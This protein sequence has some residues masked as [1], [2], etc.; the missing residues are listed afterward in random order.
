MFKL[1][2]TNKLVNKLLKAWIFPL[3]LHCT[4]DF[5]AS[6]VT[7]LE[8]SEII[9]GS[10]TQR[11]TPCRWGTGCGAILH[12]LTPTAISNHLKEHHFEFWDDRARGQCQWEGT[13][14]RNGMD[15]YF[16][17]FGKHVAC[18]HL[19][20]TTEK[21]RYC[22]ETFSR[23]DVLVRH[24]KRYCPG[25]RQI[26]DTRYILE[27]IST[28]DNE[29]FMATARFLPKENSWY[30]LLRRQCI[31]SDLGL[32][33]AICHES[34]KMFVMNHYNAPIKGNAVDLTTDFMARYA[35]YPGWVYV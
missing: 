26:F 18:V 16:G 24:E 19:R 3:Y 6:T 9:F 1:T 14:C 2:E 4:S 10:N 25:Q 31:M 15:M 28:G 34:I 29:R 30:W 23:P 7:T 11:A 27:Y 12:N 20:S 22:G 5:N 8:R 35:T 13:S 21:C 33:A 17:S 32:R